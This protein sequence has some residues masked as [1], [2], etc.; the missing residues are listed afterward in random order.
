M[1]P[2]GLGKVKQDHTQDGHATQAIG[3]IK[4]DM[5]LVATHPYSPVSRCDI[6]PAMD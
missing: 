1:L 5:L 3:K 2:E 6:T 4:T